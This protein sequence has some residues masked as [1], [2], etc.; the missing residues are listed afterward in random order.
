MRRLVAL[1]SIV[2]VLMLLAPIEARASV[3]GG[4]AYG[5][6]TVAGAIQGSGGL[7]GPYSQPSADAL[8]YLPTVTGGTTTL[9]QY[10]CSSTNGWVYSAS[11]T[12]VATDGVGPPAQ[13]TLTYSFAYSEAP[14]L[15]EVWPFSQPVGVGQFVMDGQ[16]F[17]G[18][19]ISCAGYFEIDQS[20]AEGVVRGYSFDG[21]CTV[22]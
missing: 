3:D 15:P 21:P 17:D 19:T 16:I 18:Q 1:G 8:L 14:E 22:N 6:R 4:S 2:A 7:E 20:N 10:W 5:S 12:C 13:F 11:A 9:L